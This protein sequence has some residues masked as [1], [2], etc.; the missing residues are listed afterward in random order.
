MTMKN[1]LAL[2]VLLLP[3]L[4]WAGE[5][6]S[7]DELLTA[8]D[9]NMTFQ[10]RRARMTMV[11]EGRRT[12]SY[13]II[14]YGRGQEDSA[15][16]YLA[17]AR[18]KGTRMLKLGGELWLY[19]P[20]VDRVQKISGHML[21]DGMM[22]SDLSYE[23]LMSSAELRKAYTAKVVGEEVIEGVACWKIELKAHDDTVSYPRRVSW[24][25]KDTLIPAKQELYALS[26][27]LLKTWTMS[28]AKEFPGGRRFPTK[29]VIVDN[30]KKESSTRL[31][32]KEL[33][34]GVALEQE[35]F[36]LRWLERH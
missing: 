1:H 36:A 18:D 5:L 11:V 31:E 12:R 13:D 21:R 30:V 3:S 34:F 33:E 4:G 26:G 7:A 9:K 19:L 8:M 10:T 35:V 28:D 29:M 24:V 2:L 20:G 16:E 14:S 32:F 23:D 25:T 17:P 22:G 27:L 15:M 6:P